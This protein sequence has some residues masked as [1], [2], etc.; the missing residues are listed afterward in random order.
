MTPRKPA[1][2]AYQ[3]ARVGGKLLLEIPDVSASYPPGPQHHLSRLSHPTLLWLLTSKP[4]LKKTFG[5]TEPAAAAVP[6][7]VREMVM[8]QVGQCGN[9]IG[10][11]FWTELLHEAAAQPHCGYDAAMSAMFRNV[12]ARYAP[13]VDLGVG[14]SISTLRARAILVDTEEGVVSETL[15]DPMVEGLFEDTQVVTDASGAGN[16]WACGYVSYGLRCGFRVET[17]ARKA[18]EACDSP[19]AFLFVHSVG[20]G[21]GSG[22]GS[23]LLELFQDAFP[24]LCRFNVAVYPSK[25]DE[26]VITAPYN[27]VLATERLT[28][29]SDCVIP[30]ENAALQNFGAKSM[31]IEKSLE[32]GRKK[33]GFNQ[34]NDVAAQLIAHL[35][36]SVRYPGKLNI[37][38]NEIATNLVPFPR[39]HYLTASFSP[40][41][42][43]EW[44]GLNAFSNMDAQIQRLLSEA[45]ADS[46][47]LMTYC[48][49]EG[50]SRRSLACALFTRGG[51]ISADMIHTA[52]RSRLWSRHPSWNSDGFKMGVCTVPP[53]GATSAI[54]CLNNS[55]AVAQNFDQLRSRF[56]K[57]YHAKAM[58]HHYTQLVEEQLIDGAVR[59][60]DHLIASYDAADSEIVAS[61]K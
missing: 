52:M 30:L 56:N 7:M 9:Q 8:V 43:R 45:C 54:L 34:V 53:Y 4:L 12:D 33:K 44:R 38:V 19:Q 5:I 50:A 61:W 25:H 14:H 58:L 36:A 59:D 35:T 40:Y 31:R 26:D 39:L 2:A 16:N 48:H 60:I 46:S 49:A 6:R 24:E 27:A 13:A 18:L 3:R 37:D 47:K 22:L 1:A 10:R 51:S 17:A 42:L 57:L 29:A 41:L 28:A 15:R 23:Y 32:P 20:G 55:T 21:T 11:R